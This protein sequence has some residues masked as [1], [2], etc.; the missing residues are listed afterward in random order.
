MTKS[1]RQT[2]NTQF[3]IDELCNAVLAGQPFRLVVGHSVEFIRKQLHP[4]VCG[5][6]I[7]RGLHV[8][9][10]TDWRIEVEGSIIEFVPACNL[11]R[12]LCGKR[13]WGIFI[14]HDAEVMVPQDIPSTVPEYVRGCC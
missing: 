8:V 5:E 7:V 14:D 13:G 9:T 1:G 10:V 4:R 12:S 11:E 2:G 6:L 3:L